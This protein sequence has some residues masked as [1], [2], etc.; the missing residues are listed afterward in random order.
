MSGSLI[1]RD[2][3]SVVIVDRAGGR[4]AGDDVA[5]VRSTEGDGEG[6]IKLRQGIAADGDGHGGGGIATGDGGGA[7]G[8]GAADEVGAVHGGAADGVGHVH[9]ARGVAGAG[10]GEDEVR[11]AGVAFADGGEV[12]D[13]DGF[14]QLKGSDIDGA[15]GT[16][17]GGA[18]LVHVDDF[19]GVEV[20]IEVEGVHGDLGAETGVE[21]GAAGEQGVG[22][23][24]SAVVGERGELR[25][26]RRGSV[27]DLVAAGAVGEAG[28][29]ACV[30]DEVAAAGGEGAVDVGECA[31]A[32]I[33]SDDA[34]GHG[35]RA[36]ASSHTT[37]A[38]DT[39]VVG[40]GAV[41]DGGRGE[42]TR[43]DAAA[44]ECAAAGDAVA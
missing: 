1:D 10:E 34:I 44:I 17:E 33:A 19:G 39:G 23:S 5:V 16:G 32:N 21:R 15:D 42:S 11:G 7:G 6:L 18:A 2:G 25:I 27:A 20:A 40:D 24:A 30:A 4:C 26:D 37:D 13:G 9:V 3:E 29:R 36:R 31:V 38:A 35:D 8:Q 41:T 28:G 14:L 22:L 12:A 43:I